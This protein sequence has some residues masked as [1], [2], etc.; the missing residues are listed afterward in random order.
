MTAGG[1]SSGPD[2]LGELSDAIRI[3]RVVCIVLMLTVHVWPGAGLILSAGSPAP[4][5]LFYEALIGYL[6]RSAVPLLSIIS[7][8]LLFTTLLNRN[9]SPA[10]MVRRKFQTLILPMVFWSAALLTLQVLYV[11]VS[12]M[13]KPLPDT[14]LAWM[15]AFLAIT[16]EPANAPLAFLRD[17]FLCAVVALVAFRVFRGRPLATLIVALAINAADFASG[18][19]LLLRPPIMTFYVLGMALAWRG[20]IGE[21][22]GWQPTMAV[23]AIDGA[24]RMASLPEGPEA[25]S[26]TTSLLHR[27]AMALL[28]WN[29]SLAILRRTGRLKEIILAVEPSIFLVF[30]SHMLTIAVCGRILVAIGIHPAEPIYAIFFLLQLAACV[31]AGLLMTMLRAPLLFTLIGGRKA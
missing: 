2:S 22:P 12:G 7:G 13:Q 19:L 23:L 8:Y 3:A 1:P 15:N 31:A 30:C 11:K 5:A 9:P 18:G 28:L 20:S 10:K 27:F 26:I 25:A 14:P 29:M 4:L 6:G 21:L 16:A 17:I 24:V